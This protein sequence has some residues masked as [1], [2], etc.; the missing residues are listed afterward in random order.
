MKNKNRI[1]RQNVVIM[2]MNIVIIVLSILLLC[3]ILVMTEELKYAF[4][5]F[6]D[7]DNISYNVE[8]GQ[9]SRLTEQYHM[10]IEEGVKA[11]KE[12]EEYFGVAKY[13]EA[14]YMYNAFRVV[15]DAERASR[16]EAKMEQAYEQ[17]G[18]WNIV[19]KEIHDRLGLE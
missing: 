6:S 16:E 11:N 15:G 1:Q 18:S 3:T 7:T 2:V 9:Y 5:S 12:L 14:A 13:F 17:M 8:Y 4:S 10:S 19:K